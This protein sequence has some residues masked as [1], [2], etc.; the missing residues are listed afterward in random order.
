MNEKVK[1]K[2]TDFI[3]AMAAWT[4]TQIH[5]CDILTSQIYAGPVKIDSRKYVCIRR[6]T[7]GMKQFLNV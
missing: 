4:R 7:L 6:P 1:K 5:V 2:T 3:S